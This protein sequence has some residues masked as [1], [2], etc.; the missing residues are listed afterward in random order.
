V[1]K[2]PSGVISK[3]H[4]G[5][6]GDNPG[7]DPTPQD[8]GASPAS[9]GNKVALIAG[10]I[11]AGAALLAGMGLLVNW[12]WRKFARARKERERIKTKRDVR[13]A[14]RISEYAIKAPSS[15]T[16]KRHP[17]EWERRVM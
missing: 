3:K 16:R 1:P 9:R 14:E 12:G 15:K 11:T 5:N 7:E 17:R 4:D 2:V 6:G 8:G 10:G 13:C